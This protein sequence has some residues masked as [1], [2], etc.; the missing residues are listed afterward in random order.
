MYAKKNS[1]VKAV[2]LLLCMAL[3]IGGA[4]GGTLAYLMTSTTPVVNTFTVGNI[5]TLTLSETEMDATSRTKDYMV[6][7]GVEIPKDPK[8]T[9]TG[10]N[11]A[12]YVFVKV[13]AAEGWTTT[14]DNRTYTC[15]K[16]QVSWTVDSNWTFLT[17]DGTAKVYYKEATT[18]GLSN[19]SVISDNKITVANTVLQSELTAG[20]V[21]NL[22]FT[23]YAVQK[24]NLATPAA[25]WAVAKNN[26][27]PVNP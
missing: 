25:A 4:I 2:A 12:A 23:A 7:P 15:I 13:D 18:T 16:G 9:F 22:T 10:N 17:E 21:P 20:A 6:I 14:T 24:D 26:G 3:L 5:G 27:V 8:V 11:V 1:S 19:V